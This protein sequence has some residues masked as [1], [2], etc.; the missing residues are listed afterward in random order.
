MAAV[1]LNEQH[2]NITNRLNNTS[3]L[4]LYK[5]S[6]FAHVTFTEDLLKL[7]QSQISSSA[8]L[9]SDSCRSH[10]HCGCR[11][12]PAPRVADTRVP[13]VVACRQLLGFE[14]VSLLTMTG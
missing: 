1:Q 6:T 10:N 13:T 7:H 8:S 5:I 12:V 4:T 11:V 14:T 9:S 2:L 3:L